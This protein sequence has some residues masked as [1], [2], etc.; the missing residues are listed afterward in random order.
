[1][2]PGIHVTWLDHDMLRI[3]ETAMLMT[4]DNDIF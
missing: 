2:L 4:T 1:M 3:E